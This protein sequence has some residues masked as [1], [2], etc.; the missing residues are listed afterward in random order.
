MLLE[1]QASQTLKF[2]PSKEAM[3]VTNL[4]SH[5]GGAPPLPNNQHATRGGRPLNSERGGTR[6]D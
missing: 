2:A 4:R 3:T 5:G 1:E 6:T